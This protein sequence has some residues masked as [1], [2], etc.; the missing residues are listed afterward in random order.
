MRDLT[1]DSI[2]FRERQEKKAQELHNIKCYS[3]NLMLLEDI[4][5]GQVYQV[6]GYEWTSSIDGKR[7]YWNGVCVVKLLK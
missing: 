5:I 2:E 3:G 6:G 4:S 1:L 7:K